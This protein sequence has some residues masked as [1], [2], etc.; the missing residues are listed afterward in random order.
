MYQYILNFEDVMVEEYLKKYT[1]LSKEEIDSIMKEHNNAPE[2][3]IAQ[4]KIAE[5]VITFI[6]SKEALEEAKMI[7][8]ALFSGNVK[9]LTDDQI[10]TL[11]EIEKFPITK[12]ETILEILVNNKIT[13]SRREAR[14]FLTAGA[15]TLNGLR[16]VI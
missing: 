11:K 9:D 3:R 15:I 5:E 10:E 2:K 4:R 16:T 6:H 8:E 14:E 13:S 12:E 1:F 7:S